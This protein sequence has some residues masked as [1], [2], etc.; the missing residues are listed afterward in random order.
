MKSYLLL[1]LFGINL[2]L[3]QFPLAF[4]LYCAY[5]DGSIRFYLIVG[6]QLLFTFYVFHTS[7]LTLDMQLY[8]LAFIYSFDQLVN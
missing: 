4:N 5:F 6:G 1:V 2:P 7:N 3:L 8:T